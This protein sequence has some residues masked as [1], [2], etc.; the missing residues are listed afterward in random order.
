MEI[1]LG[2]EFKFSALFWQEVIHN[3]PNTLL[4]DDP[5]FFVLVNVAVES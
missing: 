3:D 2:F 1:W 5:D 4:V